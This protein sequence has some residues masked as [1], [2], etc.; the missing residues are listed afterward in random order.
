MKRVL[1]PGSFD[2]FTVGHMDIIRRA[3][4]LFPHVVVAVMTNDMQNYVSGVWCW[5]ECSR[6]GFCASG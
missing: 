6:C 1:I 3:A 4:H 5:R 2:P